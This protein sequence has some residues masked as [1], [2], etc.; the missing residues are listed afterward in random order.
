MNPQLM[1]P[2]SVDTEFK[3][4]KTSTKA[5]LQVSKQKLE[6]AD[7]ETREKFE[8]LEAVS[9]VLCLAV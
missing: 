3:E 9:S 8:A 2:L 6:S 1:F 5:K 4:M 7:S